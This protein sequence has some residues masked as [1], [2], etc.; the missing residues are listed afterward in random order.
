[1]MHLFIVL[2]GNVQCGLHLGEEAWKL[3]NAR[4][5]AEEIPEFSQVTST[6]NPLR[7][8]NTADMEYTPINGH[9][10]GVL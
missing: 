9:A 10:E 2:V 7:A 6:S 3:R 4:N 8:S 1:M 5:E